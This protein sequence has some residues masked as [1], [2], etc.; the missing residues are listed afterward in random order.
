MFA[1]QGFILFAH[2]HLLENLTCSTL[3]KVHQEIKPQF[4][5]VIRHWHCLV[6]V[7]LI[8]FGISLLQT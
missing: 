5:I 8:G 6:E 2:R 4:L 7:I 3:R 1:L